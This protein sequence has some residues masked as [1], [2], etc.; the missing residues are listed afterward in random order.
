M[1]DFTSPCSDDGLKGA[2]GVTEDK[3]CGGP[4]AGGGARRG[5]AAE[6]HDAGDG[7]IGPGQ[8]EALGVGVHTFSSSSS[9]VERRQWGRLWIIIYCDAGVVARIGSPRKESDVFP[10]TFAVR[11]KKERSTPT[12]LNSAT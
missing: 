3:H 5:A 6:V 12:F 9:C 8:E 7:A 2:E 11:K 10:F 1:I 4:A